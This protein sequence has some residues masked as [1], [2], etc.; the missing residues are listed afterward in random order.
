VSAPLK[1][2][3]KSWCPWCITASQSLAKLG[4]RFE[5]VDVEADRAAY[6]EMIRLSGQA[7][8]PTLT[9]DGKLLADFGPDELQAF[10]QKHQIKP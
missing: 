1:L 9:V 3:V 4:Y 6:A 8:T 5:E 7:Y 10:L 2:Y